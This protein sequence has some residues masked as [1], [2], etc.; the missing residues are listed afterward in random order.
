MVVSLLG[1]LQIA[2]LIVQVESGIYAIKTKNNLFDVLYGFAI[3]GCIPN[4]S[5]PSILEVFDA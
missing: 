1:A 3:L 5:W 2:C 4:I